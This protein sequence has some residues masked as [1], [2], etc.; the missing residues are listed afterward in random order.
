MNPPIEGDFMQI[1]VCD[2]TNAESSLSRV[3]ADPIEMAFIVEL[4]VNG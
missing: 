2:F 3:F 1:S 4:D